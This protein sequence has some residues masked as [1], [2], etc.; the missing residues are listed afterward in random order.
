VAIEV[1]RVEAIDGAVRWSLVPVV[2]DEL[3]LLT[4]LRDQ[5]S[6]RIIEW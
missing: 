3:V 2:S 1:S 6:L 4:Y 5:G